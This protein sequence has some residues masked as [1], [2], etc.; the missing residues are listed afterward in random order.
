MSVHIDAQ[1]V[2]PKK[3]PFYLYKIKTSDLLQLLY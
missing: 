2:H 3:N 1:Y